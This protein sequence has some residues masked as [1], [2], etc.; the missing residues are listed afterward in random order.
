MKAY[1]IFHLK[2]LPAFLVFSDW[3]QVVPETKRITWK[4]WGNLKKKKKKKS[5]SM[6]GVCVH[7][8]PLDMS[9]LSKGGSSPK[10]AP[11]E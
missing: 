4:D 11:L 5:G 3:E 8:I 6:W 9:N 2:Q 10:L 1:Y 7:A